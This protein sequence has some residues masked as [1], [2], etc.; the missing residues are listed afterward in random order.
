MGDDVECKGLVTPA[1]RAD[2]IEK[3]VKDGFSEAREKADDTD[4]GRNEADYGAS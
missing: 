2:I 1:T 3:L 4:R